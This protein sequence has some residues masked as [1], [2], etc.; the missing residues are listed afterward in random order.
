MLYASVSAYCEGD[1][2][3]SAR[4]HEHASVGPSFE[5]VP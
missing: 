5:G 2:H 4:E 1:R 3:G